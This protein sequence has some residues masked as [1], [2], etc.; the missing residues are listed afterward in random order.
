L[1]P[2]SLSLHRLRRRTGAVTERASRRRVRESGGAGERGGS[3]GAVVRAVSRSTLACRNRASRP[4]I[5]I[6]WCARRSRFTSTRASRSKS[7]IRRGR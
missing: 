2:M 6:R 1:T 7:P 4:S 5:S 3:D